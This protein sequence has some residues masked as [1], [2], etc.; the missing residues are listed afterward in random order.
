MR[1]RKAGYAT[2]R[3][4]TRMFRRAIPESEIEFRSTLHIA[5]LGRISCPSIRDLVEPLPALATIA[6]RSDPRLVEALPRHR[7]PV[8]ERRRACP[9][10]DAGR[11]RLVRIAPCLA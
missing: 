1:P 4:L 7:G 2:S 10:V 5:P 8:A 11:G 6:R 3:S 9:E